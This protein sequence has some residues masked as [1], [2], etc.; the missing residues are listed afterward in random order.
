MNGVLVSTRDV[1]KRQPYRR[2]YV[3]GLDGFGERRDDALA[4][5]DFFHELVEQIHDRRHV[6]I[7]CA[8]ARV[9]GRLAFQFRCLF[10]VYAE[11]THRVQSAAAGHRA[12][13]FTVRGYR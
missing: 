4:R 5:F 6:L 12:A 2:Q 7:D 8:K 3:L 11:E 13:I 1:Y 10:L 9:R